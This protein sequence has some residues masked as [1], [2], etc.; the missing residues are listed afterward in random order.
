MSTR[1]EL[2]AS[3]LTIDEINAF[4]GADSLGYLSLD[5]LVRRRV[6]R[7]MTSAA[8][9][10]TASIRSRSGASQE[11]RAGRA[12]AAPDPVNAR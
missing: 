12:V 11:V 1:Q 9:A 2:V 5:G 10:S 7:R 6:R 4:L 3:D 8:R